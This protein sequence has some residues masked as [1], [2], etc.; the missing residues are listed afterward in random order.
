MEIKDYADDELRRKLENITEDDV[1]VFDHIDNLPQNE[2]IRT[3]FYIV[4]MCLG[5]KA[6][7]RIGEKTFE[8]NKNDIFL[9]HPQQF[10]ENA[11]ASMDF[12]CQGIVVS[13][14]YLESIF[15]LGGNLWNAKLAIRETPVIHLTEEE[16]AMA[17]ANNNFIHDKLSGPRLPHRK[18]QLKLLFQSLIYEFYDTLMPK[19]PTVSHTYT[20]AE[21]LFN[22]FMD[23]A[24]AET[25][26]LREVKD[27]ADRLCVT[28]KYL[29]A[30]CKQISGSTASAILNRLTVDYIKRELRASDKTIK[31]VASAAGFDNLSFFGK[32]VRRELGVSPRE[33]RTAQA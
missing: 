7:C 26:R 19:L 1:V 6:S 22:R 31:E 11:M 17:V 21:T 20:S 23:L 30:A 14:N 10:V 12:K 8:V 25:P 16:M 13:P 24:T 29:S 3:E 9:C 32:Y 28:P 4:L 33:Y 18:D 27:Y 15:L 2:N 5:G